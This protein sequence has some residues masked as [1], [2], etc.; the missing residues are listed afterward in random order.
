MTPGR[1]YLR[2]PQVTSLKCLRSL[3]KWREIISAIHTC[4]SVSCRC[5]ARDRRFG[6]AQLCL[7][8]Q[9]NNV[10]GVFFFLFLDVQ[11]PPS[12]LSLLLMKYAPWLAAR[13]LS[14]FRRP[15]KSTPPP[16]PGRPQCEQQAGGT[17]NDG[18]RNGWN[19]RRCP[20]TACKLFQSVSRNWR[21]IFFLIKKTTFCLVFDVF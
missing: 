13:T 18:G 7:H 17:K 6:N 20:I 19:R 9:N 14:R 5:A 4:Q 11:G 2:R 3:P 15:W 10:Q 12:S 16:F 1:L 8:K 21:G